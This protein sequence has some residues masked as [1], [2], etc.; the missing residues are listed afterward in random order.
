MMMVEAAE[1]ARDAGVGALL[2]THFSTSLEDPEA[3]LPAARAVFEKT[4]AA[5]DGL[6]V[7]LRYPTEEE[8]A[9]TSLC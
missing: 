2:L 5:S 3:C 7:T 9:W 1:L 6:A 8:N 4:F